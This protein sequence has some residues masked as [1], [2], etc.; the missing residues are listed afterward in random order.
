MNDNV[1]KWSGN[2]EK[3][4][5]G[6]ISVFIMRY[7]SD[8]SLI[9]KAKQKSKMYVLFREFLL[10]WTTQRSQNLFC[11]GPLKEIRLWANLWSTMSDF[12]WLSISPKIRHNVR[13]DANDCFRRH[14][15]VVYAT[16]ILP[17]RG[18]HRMARKNITRRY[19]T[20]A[21]ILQIEI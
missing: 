3:Y 7:F 11:P 17:R 20:R 15:S 5:Y 10:L 13:C 19:Y 2:S 4:F 8:R 14:F 9:F 6:D 16:Q 18:C 21:D 1:G 12:C